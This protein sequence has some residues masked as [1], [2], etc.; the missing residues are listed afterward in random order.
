MLGSWFLVLWAVSHTKAGNRT[1]FQISHPPQP[2]AFQHCLPA[3]AH[4]RCL[5]VVVFKTLLDLGPF[6]RPWM[7]PEFQDGLPVCRNTILH[8]IEGVAYYY[9]Y[10]QCQTKS[11]LMPYSDYDLK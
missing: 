5:V 1:H 11:V 2:T 10:S 9:Q 3:G 7:S 4:R 6:Q 8:S